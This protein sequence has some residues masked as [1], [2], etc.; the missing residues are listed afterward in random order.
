MR[1]WG[2]RWGSGGTGETVGDT[3]ETVGDTGGAVGAQVRQ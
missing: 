2:H 3:G 1:Q